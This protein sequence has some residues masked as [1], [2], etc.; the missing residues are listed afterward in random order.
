MSTDKVSRVTGVIIEGL[1][2]LMPHV[3]EP[4]DRTEAHKRMKA[5]QL[6]DGTYVD[7]EMVGYVLRTYGAAAGWRHSRNKP[8]LWIPYDLVE[9]CAP[10]IEERIIALEER[11]AA[12]EAK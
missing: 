2:C 7:S 5:L 3:K 1:R 8:R 9:T 11:V 12:L 4:I 10:S 6:I